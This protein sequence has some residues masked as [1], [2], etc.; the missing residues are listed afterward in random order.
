MD[1]LITTLIVIL[2]VIGGALVTYEIFLTFRL[3]KLVWA[4]WSEKK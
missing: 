2:S 4:S 1:Y 3:L